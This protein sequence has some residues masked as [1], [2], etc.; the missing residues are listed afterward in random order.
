[1]SIKLEVPIAKKCTK[2]TLCP[3][4]GKRKI[5]NWVQGNSIV[6]WADPHY[7]CHECYVVHC[8][9]MYLELVKGQ[10][11]WVFPGKPIPPGRCG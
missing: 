4:C 10:P 5:C 2:K 7:V 9:L 3:Q 8:H 6:G 11:A 1:M